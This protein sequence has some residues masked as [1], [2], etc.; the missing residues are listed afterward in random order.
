MYGQTLRGS[1]DGCPRP[2]QSVT[3]AF[4]RNRLDLGLPSIVRR[5]KTTLQKSEESAMNTFTSAA[6]IL[7][8]FCAVS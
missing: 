3:T 7:L 5:P 1:S 2:L 4:V 6:D 8:R